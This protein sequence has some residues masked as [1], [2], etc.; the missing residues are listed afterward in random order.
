V[1]DDCQIILKGRPSLTESGY[2]LLPL[3]RLLRRVCDYCHIIL[4]GPSLPE[5]GYL[6]LPLLRLLMRVGP[7]GVRLWS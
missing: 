7:V 2:L 5:P 1:C 4:K 6:L 3:L